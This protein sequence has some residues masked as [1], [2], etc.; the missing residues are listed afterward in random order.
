MDLSWSEVFEKSVGVPESV[1]VPPQF[2][3]PNICYE[4]L[5]LV[6]PPQLALTN[7]N[8]NLSKLNTS[9]TEESASLT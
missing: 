5:P 9:V 6:F 7:A 8:L 2:G 4:P 3:N 1:S